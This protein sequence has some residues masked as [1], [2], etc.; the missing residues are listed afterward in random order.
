MNA[1]IRTG[2]FKLAWFIAGIAVLPL[3]AA[4]AFVAWLGAGALLGIFDDSW[5]MAFSHG[6]DL[7]LAVFWLINGFCIG[8]LQRALVRRYLRV[9]L[10]RW[11]VYSS[12]GALLAGALAYPCLE[13]DCL[14]PQIYDYRFDLDLA[15]TIELSLVALVYLTVFST[16]QCLALNRLVSASWRWIA[17]HA[18]PLILAALV[19][20]A[21][22]KS[23]GWLV[24]DS[25]LAFALYVLVVTVATGLIMQRL[26]I[27]NR[28]ATKEPIDEWAYQPA[29]IEPDSPV[30]RSVWD[31]AT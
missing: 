29:P 23:P 1:Q 27:T 15:A 4:V 26:I 10:G 19:S 20:V 9:D 30:Q 7:V 13:G 12:L 17:A 21:G 31:D 18:V 22:Q 24:F 28:R 2:R 3:S 25:G 11:T 5:Y 8:F 6:P 16:V 14:P